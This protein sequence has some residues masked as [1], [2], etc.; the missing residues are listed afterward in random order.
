M[1]WSQFFIK[2]LE[3]HFGHSVLDNPDWGKIIHSLTKKKLKKYFEQSATLF[4]MKRK[5][6]KPSPLIQILV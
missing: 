1:V 3:L 5:N 2:I 4:G 6:C